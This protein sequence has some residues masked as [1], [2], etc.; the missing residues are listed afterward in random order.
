MPNSQPKYVVSLCFLTGVLSGNI[1]LALLLI[2]GSPHFD[3]LSFMSYCLPFYSCA[4]NLFM[5]AMFLDMHIVSSAY[6]TS[7]KSAPGTLP[8]ESV[9]SMFL[10]TS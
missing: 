4:I 8:L 3:L 9:S 7:S 6:V 2:G 1:I 10:C 5:A